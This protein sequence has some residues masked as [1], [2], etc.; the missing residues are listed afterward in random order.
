MAEKARGQCVVSAFTSPIESFAVQKWMRDRKLVAASRPSAAAV[1]DTM[2]SRN[3]MPYVSDSY[4]N[5]RN[6]S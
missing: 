3:N 5:I 1:S 4:R 6:S 2:M